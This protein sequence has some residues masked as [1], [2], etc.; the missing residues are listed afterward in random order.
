MKILIALIAL[1][2]FMNF[3]GIT[4][5]K[6]TVMNPQTEKVYTHA[7]WKVKPGMQEKFITAWEQLAKLFS[8]L[9]Q[10]PVEKGVLIQSLN[11]QTLYY[12]FGPW[13]KMDDLTAM[14]NNEDVQKA[15]Q[16]LRQLCEEMTPGAYKL[17][18]EIKL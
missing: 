12:S 14:R 8:S 15:M 6:E 11:D 3:T 17:I 9:P 13:E 1:F 2:S 5:T 10:P 18:R 4:K 16:Q 7:M